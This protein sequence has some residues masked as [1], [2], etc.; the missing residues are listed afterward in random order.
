MHALQRTQPV[1]QWLSNIAVQK[2]VP[3]RYLLLL[4]VGWVAVD[5]DDQVAH[6]ATWLDA[7]EAAAFEYR[8]VNCAGKAAAS[9]LP[10]KTLFLQPVTVLNCALAAVITFH[11]MP[12][13]QKPNDENRVLVPRR[14]FQPWGV[15]K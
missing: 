1:I 12:G 13:Q 7:G 5:A 11:E 2:P 3:V 9:S 10:T 4:R 14:Q 8:V 15:V 6:Q